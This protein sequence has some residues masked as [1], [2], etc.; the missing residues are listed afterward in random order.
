MIFLVGNRECKAQRGSIDS[1]YHSG[2]EGWA[3]LSS[4]FEKSFY[5]SIFWDYKFLPAQMCMLYIALIEIAHTVPQ[6]LSGIVSHVKDGRWFE[7]D[8]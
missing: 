6:W 7:P 5:F 4:F 1:L 3:V 8:S 2:W